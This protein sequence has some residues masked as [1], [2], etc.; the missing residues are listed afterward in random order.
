MPGADARPSTSRNATAGAIAEEL[1][2]AHL[3]AHGLTIVARNYRTRFGEI[4]LIARDHDTLVFVE[5]RMRSR[6]DFGGACASISR[7][8]Q[9]RLIRAARGYLALIGDEPACRFD[10]VL[11]TRPDKSAVTWLR[12]IIES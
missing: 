9:A 11:L 12:N 5:V 7:A 3:K 2:A 4:D 8:K 6:E 1:A 10:A